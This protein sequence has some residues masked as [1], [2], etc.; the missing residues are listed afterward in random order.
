V[1]RI[2][3]SRFDQG[4][5]EPSGMQLLGP[6]RCDAGSQAGRAHGPSLRHSVWGVVAATR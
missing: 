1:L 4:I 5:G 6:D 2:Q 3:A